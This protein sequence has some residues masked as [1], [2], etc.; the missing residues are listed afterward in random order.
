LAPKEL[1]KPR[2]N[3][4]LKMRQRTVDKE[5]NEEQTEVKDRH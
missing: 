5:N 4:F 3:K 2:K 1:A